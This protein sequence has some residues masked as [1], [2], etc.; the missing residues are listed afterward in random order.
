MEMILQFDRLNRVKES[1][2]SKCS[3]FIDSVRFGGFLSFLLQ[4]GSRRHFHLGFIP[5][6]LLESNHVTFHSLVRK[7]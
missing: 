5:N 4:A 1:S 7:A 6:F 3:Y 2:D